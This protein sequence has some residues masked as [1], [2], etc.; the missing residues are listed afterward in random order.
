MYPLDQDK[1]LSKNCAPWTSVFLIKIRK[2]LKKAQAWCL[3]RILCGAPSS[4]LPPAALRGACRRLLPILGR[5]RRLRRASRK[6]GKR[7]MHL[8]GLRRTAPPC[9]DP[10][11]SFVRN[12][13]PQAR[14][15]H[16]SFAALARGAPQATGS[17]EDRQ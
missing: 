15:V 16:L 11:D 17:A 1:N 13:A 14:K 8:S 7:W 10:L 9:C 2:K 3:Y 4:P 5:P 6:R 12:S